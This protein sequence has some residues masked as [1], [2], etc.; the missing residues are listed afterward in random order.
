VSVGA[1]AHVFDVER[2][3]AG[4]GV[5]IPTGSCPTVGVSGLALG[6]GVGLA[7]RAWGTTSDNLVEVQIVTADGRVLTC[8]H[9]RNSELFWGCRGGGGG[10]F[11]IATR[12]RFRVHPVSSVSWFVASWPW[13]QAE[14]VVAAWQAFAPH[15]PDAL[16]TLCR[17]AQGVGTPSIQVF[18]QF[19]GSESGLRT[20]LSP[21]GSVSGMRLTTG[22]STYLEAQLRWA[23]C[24]G[25]TPAACGAPGHATFAAKSD[26]ANAP[27]TAAGIA[28]LRRRIEVAQSQSWGSASVILDSYGGALNRPRPGATAFVHRNALFSMQELAY[29]SGSAGPRGPAWLRGLHAE[30][31]PHVSGFAYQ[32]YI[33]PDL[34]TWKHAYYGANLGRL[35]ALKRSVDPDGFFRF[36]QSIPTH[37]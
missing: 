2:T 31:R 15:A 14:A 17:L 12:F 19:I 26:Y 20:L 6:G 22:T 13:S 21:L 9:S 10:N 7:S 5:A 4:H 28:V 11:G 37:L 3:L 23:G 36:A 27:L 35:V 30:L 29:W 16:F 33:D 8:N 1:G 25:K 24:L 32:N 34:V 18:G